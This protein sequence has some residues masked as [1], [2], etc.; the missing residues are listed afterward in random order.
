[1]IF[2]LNLKSIFY[3]SHS[4]DASIIFEFLEVRIFS[5]HFI[6][7]MP[8]FD[9][10]KSIGPEHSIQLFIYQHCLPAFKV[11]MKNLSHKV[12]YG[13]K[14]VLIFEDHFIVEALD[15]KTGTAV[16]DGEIGELVF[17]TGG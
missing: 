13:F 3:S 8:S 12:E 7:N 6:L 11:L 17:T 9:Q 2:F 4:I 15:P 1:M 5:E 14:K 16:P 10:V